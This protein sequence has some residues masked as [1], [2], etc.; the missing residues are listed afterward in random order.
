MDPDLLSSYDCWWYFGILT[1]QSLL[2][3]CMFIYYFRER[4]RDRMCMSRGTGRGRGEADS[5][6]SVEPGWGGGW[7]PHPEIMSWAETESDAGYLTDWAPWVPLLISIFI[8]FTNIVPDH[9]YTDV[10]CSPTLCQ[11]ASFPCQYIL[12]MIFELALSI[13]SYGFI[14]VL[15]RCHHLLMLDI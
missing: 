6:L 14:T 10:A 11:M 9:V 7:I 15:W 8:C 2:F 1:L 12:F 5:L 3:L 4:E 13:P